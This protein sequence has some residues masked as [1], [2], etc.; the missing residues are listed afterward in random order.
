MMSKIEVTVADGVI[1]VG[2]LLTLLLLY[3]YY[4]RE[5]TE[6]ADYALVRVDREA[7]LKI[8]LNH[9]HIVKIQGVLGENVLQI[10]KGKIRVIASP[11]QGKQCIHAGWLHHSGDFTAC[12]PN[13]VSIA[14]HQQGETQFDEIAY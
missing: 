6:P 4:W 7:P 9:P 10:D 8:E 3:S 1:I 11:C 12:L 14:V 13:R 2:A 5:S